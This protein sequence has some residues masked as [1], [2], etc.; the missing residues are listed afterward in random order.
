MFSSADGFL[1][2]A[3]A[4]FS[5]DIAKIGPQSRIHLD[6]SIG[7][8]APMHVIALGAT[9]IFATLFLRKVGFG[10]IDLVFAISAGQLALFPVVIFAL[11]KPSGSENLRRW[12]LASVI[13]GFFSA[14]LNGFFSV[15][16]TA[17]HFVLWHWFEGIIPRD[18]YRS[19]IY[20]LCVSSA[21][22][23]FGLITSSR[24]INR[25]HSP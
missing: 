13:A 14:W 12:A 24:R 22:F 5:L 6:Q 20:S 10:V 17:S 21:V 11:W 18:V 1:N 8:I 2:S 25:S 9:A 15:S 3:A 19:P 23:A 16:D 4:T 7:W